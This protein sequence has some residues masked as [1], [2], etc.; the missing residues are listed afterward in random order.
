LEE[1]VAMDLCRMKEKSDVI[2]R[3]VGIQK[4]CFAGVG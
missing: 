4:C 2:D 1:E 3:G